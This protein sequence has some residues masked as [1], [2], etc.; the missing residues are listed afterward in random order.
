MQKPRKNKRKIAFK[1]LSNDYKSKMVRGDR[2]FY[3]DPWLE[4]K[5]MIAGRPLRKKARK[6]RNKIKN[7][8]KK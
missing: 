6:A 4:R 1:L 7:A 8:N 5:N 2:L 3:T